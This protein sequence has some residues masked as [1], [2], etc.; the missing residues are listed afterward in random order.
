MFME[1]DHTQ[2]L[3]APGTH[4][5]VCIPPVLWVSLPSDHARVVRVLLGFSLPSV[6]AA[7]VPP[8]AVCRWLPVFSGSSHAPD[9]SRFHFCVLLSAVVFVRSKVKVSCCL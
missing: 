8:W 4:L 1:K 3:L 2:W 7:S 6:F 9:E 5:G